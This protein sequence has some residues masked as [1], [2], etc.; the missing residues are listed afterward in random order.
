MTQIVLEK[1]PTEFEIS[2]A[3]NIINVLHVDDELGLLD[4]TKQILEL[5]GDFQV[6]SSNSVKQGLQ[7]LQENEFDVIVSDYQMPVIDGLDF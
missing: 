4:T 3:H 6:T 5:Q 7:M 2:Q 1:P